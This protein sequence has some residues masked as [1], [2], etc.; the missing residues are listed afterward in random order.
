[1]NNL[2]AC[3][4][5]GHT[6]DAT[7]TFIQLQGKSAPVLV[8]AFEDVPE[9]D[10]KEEIKISHEI[11]LRKKSMR[12]TSPAGKEFLIWHIWEYVKDERHKE[13]NEYLSKKIA[14]EFDPVM[15]GYTAPMLYV[16]GVDIADKEVYTSSDAI[17]T[18][19]STYYLTMYSW[20]YEM[21]LPY[22]CKI[23]GEDDQV[24]LI[25]GSSPDTNET[26][27]LIP[28]SGWKLMS[29]NSSSSFKNPFHFM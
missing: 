4:I 29:Y 9:G 25:P 12:Y 17:T 26:D 24:E 18:I 21:N 22:V 27:S 15:M 2:E 28:Y 20:P 8:A 13:K 14:K 10:P 5:M 11:I 7:R 6:L 1:M 3:V 19:I 23:S 16:E